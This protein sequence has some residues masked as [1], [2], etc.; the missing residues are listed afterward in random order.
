MLDH[1]RKV[2]AGIARFIG[3]GFRGEI[4]FIACECTG[5]ESRMRSPRELREAALKSEIRKVMLYLRIS[6]L[7]GAVFI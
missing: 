1:A 4:M 6:S 2:T 5:V 3:L 7:T